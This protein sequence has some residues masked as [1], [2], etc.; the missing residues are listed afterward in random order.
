M[1]NSRLCPLFVS[2]CFSIRYLIARCTEGIRSEE[3]NLWTW[4]LVLWGDELIPSTG[5]KI[6]F[7][8]KCLFL[9]LLSK[10]HFL[11]RISFLR[12]LG[13]HFVCLLQ[14]VFFRFSVRRSFFKPRK[15]WHQSCPVLDWSWTVKLNDNKMSPTGIKMNVKPALV[16]VILSNWPN[17]LHF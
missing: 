4:F 5:I 9:F 11:F 2:F 8:T 12:N 13:F 10:L 17:V 1:Q 16:Q 14:S 6:N 15:I 7:H 3:N